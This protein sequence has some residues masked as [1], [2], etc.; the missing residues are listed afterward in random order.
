L[1]SSVI[2]ENRAPAEFY[3]MTTFIGG[4]R[5]AEL[6]DES[7]EILFN[8]AFE[9]LNDL[10]GL[11]NK[12]VF[13]K[14]RRWERAIPQYNL[15]YEKVVDSI[16]SFKMENPGFLFCSNFYRGVSV[17]DCIKS[18]LTTSEEVSD[19]LRKNF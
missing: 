6:F 12:P 10:L 7:D 19:Y 11:K 18:S 5:N 4:V 15:G 16:E 9:E 14:I 13:Q 1:W 2:F 17:G 8:L 3:L